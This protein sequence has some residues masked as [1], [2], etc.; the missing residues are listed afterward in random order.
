M[1]DREEAGT[2]GAWVVMGLRG[3]QAVGLPKVAGW[4]VGPGMMGVMV[5][6]ALPAVQ[7]MEAA[8]KVRTGQQG[9]RVRV[10][11]EADAWAARAAVEQGAVATA[12]DLVAAV[13]D[14]EARRVGKGLMGGWVVSQAWG[15]GGQVVDA[16]G[17]AREVVG[18]GPAEALVMCWLPAGHRAARLP[19]QG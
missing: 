8:G 12:V 18:W 16:W 10:A 17:C 15:F 5:H 11:A 4:V 3:A 9:C 13:V 7:V 19:A 1:G 14:I 6:L 2:M